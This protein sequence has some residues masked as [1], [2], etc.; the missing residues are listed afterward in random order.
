MDRVE[1]SEALIEMVVDEFLA[2]VCVTWRLSD[3]AAAV[4]RAEI[5]AVLT[6]RLIDAE[7]LVK[8]V[9]ED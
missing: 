8:P 7:L 4:L 3:S 9:S 5:I 1:H 2:G 6:A